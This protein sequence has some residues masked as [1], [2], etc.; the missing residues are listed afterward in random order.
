MK[1]RLFQEMS[2][3]LVSN[4]ISM[5]VG[6]LSVLIIPKFIG[7]DQFGYYQLYLFYI[8][9]VTIT[10]LGLADGNYL[11]IGGK[12]YDKLNKLEQSSQFWLLMIS[13]SILYLLGIILISTIFTGEERFVYLMVCIGAII[14]HARYYIYLSLQATERIKEY[15]I[16]IITERLMSV[17]VSI[18]IVLCGYKGYRL[19][20]ALDVIGRGASLVI[21]VGYCRD[22]IFIRP[23]LD[24][25]NVSLALSNMKAGAMVLFSTLSST[26]IVGI[27]RF[28]VQQAWGIETFS[29]IS[30]TVSISNMAT[31]CINAVG[32]VMFPTLRKLEKERLPDIYQKINTLLMSV[33]FALFIFYQPAV[34]I[35]GKWLPNYAD[36]LKYA[37]ILLPVCAY[38]CKNVLLVS[39]YLKTLFKERM[40]LISN[41]IAISI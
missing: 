2:Y 3:S 35:L 4:I 22:Y 41:L 16:I 36:S 24:H 10:A 40:L 13:Q 6:M 12:E 1:K 39:T 9:Y 20:V 37:A 25:S 26:I 18:I 7:V 5:V 28:A 21:A 38:E 29:K 30:L 31:R 8:G 19:L 34:F 15:A 23:K 14:V 32:I 33:V 27:S 17:L 11:R